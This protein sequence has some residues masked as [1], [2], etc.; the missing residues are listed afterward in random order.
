[1]QRALQMLKK[2]TTTV[3]FGVLRHRDSSWAKSSELGP[4]PAYH[5]VGPV[6]FL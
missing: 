3:R 1:M 5:Q 6:G 2:S 4:E